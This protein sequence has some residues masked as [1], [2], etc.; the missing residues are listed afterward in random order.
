MFRNDGTLHDRI[1]L[2][3]GERRVIPLIPQGLLDGLLPQAVA[4]LPCDW[5][6]SLS[7]MVFP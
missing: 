4:T 1:V 7:G 6:V 2:L 5:P 3:R